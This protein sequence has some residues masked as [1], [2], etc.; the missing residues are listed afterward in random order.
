MSL[1]FKQMG[2]YHAGPAFL[3]LFSSAFHVNSTEKLFQKRLKWSWLRVGCRLFAIALCGLL[4]FLMW[5]P[6]DPRR[7]LIRL[8]PFDR[9]IY[10]DK[11]ANVWCTTSVVIKWNIWFSRETLVRL[12]MISTIASH[13]PIFFAF[14][15]K[16]NH[17]VAKL[18]IQDLIIWCLHSSLCFFLFSYQVHEKS[19]LYATC[20][21]N[22]IAMWPPQHAIASKL[23]DIRA[24]SL[25]NA[26]SMF[27]WVAR[28]P[29]PIPPSTH[30][31]TQHRFVG[32]E[33]EWEMSCTHTSVVPV[34]VHSM[35]PLFVKDANVYGYWSLQVIHAM[36]TYSLIRE[37]QSIDSIALHRHQCQWF[38]MPFYGVCHVH[39][40]W[41]NDLLCVRRDI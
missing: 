29:S 20:V 28:L 2:L 24:V 40:W 11:V 38:P 17:F 7:V 41:V 16:M 32:A 31:N 35:Y 22:V 14:L 26:V 9:G 34:I 39:A 5:I 4:P 27:R 8:F 13:W 25:F 23:G 37:W 1:N 18:T 33:K 12:C 3:Y 19:I 36:V 30:S 6:V 21:L 15:R 10:E